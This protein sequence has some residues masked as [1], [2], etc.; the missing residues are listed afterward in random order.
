MYTITTRG[1]YYVINLNYIYILL[2]KKMY[3]SW[4]MW[5]GQKILDG[6][7]RDAQSTTKSNIKACMWDEY[8]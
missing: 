3:L 4:F 7:L 6:N 1:K 8:D 5:R 2:Y